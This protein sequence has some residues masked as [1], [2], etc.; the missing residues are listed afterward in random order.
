[1]AKSVSR[2]YSSGFSHPPLA[3]D[4]VRMWRWSP[5][6]ITQM[7]SLQN[8]YKRPPMKSDRRDNFHV[9]S[10]RNLRVHKLF[11]LN[12]PSLKLVLTTS[13]HKRSLV[14]IPKDSFETYR[15]P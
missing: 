13:G 9:T 6:D 15:V 8:V 3:S 7:K 12:R 10:K 14:D 1:M 5:Y 4:L 11:E 2:L